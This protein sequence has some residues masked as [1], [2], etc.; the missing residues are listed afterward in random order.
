VRHCCERGLTV[1]DL[2]IGEAKYKDLFCPDAEP[3]FDS[4]WPLSA[5][6]RRVASV[7]RLAAA[8]KRAIKQRPALWSLIVKV[9]RLKAR[10]AGG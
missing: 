4:Y 3:M 8:A 7:F 5:T 6:G 10:L 9:R 1:F 2:G